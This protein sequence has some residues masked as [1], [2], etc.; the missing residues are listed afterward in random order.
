MKR[1]EMKKRNLIFILLLSL[2][3]S[4]FAAA[5]PLKYDSNSDQSP[6]EFFESQYRKT[7]NALSEDE[8]FAIAVSSI[9]FEQCGDYHLDFSNKTNFKPVKG[10]KTGKDYLNK[11]WEITDYKSLIENYNE[12]LK[13]GLTQGYA[14]LVKTLEKYT[15][16]SVFEIAV[17]EDYTITATARIYY[18]QDMKDLIGCHNLEAWDLSRAVLILRWGIGTGYITREEV[19]EL[20]KPVVQKIKDDYYDFEDFAAHWFAGFCYN[21]IYY[22]S[23]PDC[24][25]TPLQCYEKA[26]AYIPFE[27]LTFTAKNAD[28]KHRMRLD[29]GI[30]VPSDTAKKMYPAQSVYKKYKE[31]EPDEDILEELI[32]VEK[33]YPEVSDILFDMHLDLMM[34]F[35]STEQI[36]E[37]IESKKYLWAL[38]PHNSYSYEWSVRKY[39]GYL[40]CLY[41]PEKVIALYE[42]LPQKLQTDNEACYYYGYAHY[43]MANLCTTVLERD[44]YNSRAR[45][46]FK[47]IKKRGGELTNFVDCW[48]ESEDSL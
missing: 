40:N 7:W 28:K 4:V 10:R 9:F 2:V 43:L 41:M 26:R 19:A 1:F 20:I 5:Y 31:E 35:S 46:I 14:S 6:K 30:Y 27:E 24:I 29:D 13:E 32:K 17:K 33:D 45:S 44:V 34:S 23:L 42:T 36:V 11:N 3:Y 22:V 37:Y 48:L 21:E 12:L 15:D 38:L 25:K 8:Q 16:T 39:M 47:Q 18:I